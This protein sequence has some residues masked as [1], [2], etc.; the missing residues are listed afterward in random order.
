MPLNITKES[1]QIFG[2]ILFTQNFFS[3]LL[4][5]FLVFK[6]FWSMGNH[7]N[8]PADTLNG[9]WT[10]WSCCGEIDK[11]E[12]NEIVQHLGK[13][14]KFWIFI[15]LIW[16]KDLWNWQKFTHEILC[17]LIKKWRLVH[18]YWNDSFLVLHGKSRQPN[19]CLEDVIAFFEVLFYASSVPNLIQLNS[20]VHSSDSYEYQETDVIR[21]FLSLNRCVLSRVF[22]Y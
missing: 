20:S 13:K 17:G 3:S 22:F 12:F 11:I 14:D 4:D 5:I 6:I 2:N 1:H 9:E 21:V 18:V 7:N 8:S 19:R 16:R 15:E 10:D